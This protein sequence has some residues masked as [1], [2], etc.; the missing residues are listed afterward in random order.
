MATDLQQTLRRITQKCAV[1]TDRYKVVVAERDAALAREQSLRESL[2]ET[3]TA[4]ERAVDEAQYLR[5]SAALA[6][7]AGTVE[8][9]KDIIAGLVQDIDRCLT[10]LKE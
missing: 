2:A 4:L 6:P 3:Q 5:I 1:L 7:D 9:V 8:Q 10:D